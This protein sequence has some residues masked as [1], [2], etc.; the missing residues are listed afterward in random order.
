MN[1][2]FNKPKIDLK[3]YIPYDH[4]RTVESFESRKA[5]SEF[6]SEVELKDNFMKRLSFK[7]PWDGKLYAYVRQTESLQKLFTEHGL[8]SREIESIS[9]EDWDGQFVL[10]METADRR[11]DLSFFV[12]ADDMWYLLEH[13]CRI[14]KQK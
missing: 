9:F 12:S 2:R 5:K 11:R 6:N 3:S 4:F 14:P 10:I 7:V 1:D 13:C 8:T